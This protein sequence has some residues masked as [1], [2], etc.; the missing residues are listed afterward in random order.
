MG[1]ATA[2]VDWPQ[3]LKYGLS[4]NSVYRCCVLLEEC[5]PIIEYING[6]DNTVADAQSRLEYNPIK[7]INNLNSY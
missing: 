2:S 5:G 3:K 6:V 4:S 7:N 1:T